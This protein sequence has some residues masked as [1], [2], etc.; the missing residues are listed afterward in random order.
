MRLWHYKMIPYLPKKQLISQWRECVACMEIYRAPNLRG[1][2]IKSPLIDYIKNYDPTWLTF[3]TYLVL[4]EFNKRGFK[5]SRKRYNEFY[6]WGDIGYFF[7]NN[8]KEDDYPMFKEHNNEYLKICYYNLKEKYLRGI[9]SD[10]EWKILDDFY[11]EE[12]KCKQ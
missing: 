10:E 12:I 2:E 5:Y 6:I 3:Y 1:K 8:L 11:K 4:K 7:G 9:I